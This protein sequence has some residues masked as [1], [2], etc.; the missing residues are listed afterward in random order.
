MSNTVFDR[1]LL[2]GIRSGHIPARTQKA[3]DWFREKASRTGRQ[4]N[5]SKI[6]AESPNKKTGVLP[7]KM[8]FFRYDPKHKKTLPYYDTFPLIFMVEKAK[9][10]FYGINMHYLPPVLR[11]KLMDALYVLKN[12][13]KFDDTTR[14]RLSYSVLKKAAR[15]SLFKPTF[16]HYLAN[17]VKTQFVEIPSSEWDLALFLPVAAFKKRTAPEVW[18]KSREIAGAN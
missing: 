2:D 3:R 12:N 18:A 1:L 11:A 16:K 15:F 5:Q 10:G 17:H 8:Y 14:L 6:I 13:K 4:L 9:G 7:G